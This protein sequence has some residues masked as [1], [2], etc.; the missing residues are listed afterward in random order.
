MRNARPGRIDCVWNVR[1][2]NQTGKFEII[3]EELKR[4]EIDVASISETHWQGQ[5]HFKSTS[6]TM[7]RS[8]TGDRNIHG[9]GILVANKLTDFVMG[10][11]AINERAMTLKINAKPCALNI[12][13]L[14]APT[15]D[16]EDEE[17]EEFYQTVEDAINKIPNKEILFIMGDFNAKIGSTLHDDHIRQVVGKFGLGDRNERGERLIDFCIDNSLTIVN[18]LFDHHKRRL[19]TWRSPDGRTKNQIDYILTRQRWKS[20][21]RAAKTLPS[22]DCG[23]DHQLLLCEFIGKLKVCKRRQIKRLPKISSDQVA[24]FNDDA[25]R[26]IETRLVQLQTEDPEAIWQ[27]LKESLA[28]TLNELPEDI[29]NSTRQP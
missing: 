27:A 15:L 17:V 23:R 14:Y 2:L 19:Y 16:A 20:S 25:M 3:Q 13:A 7:Y 26:K 4:C 1:G 6:Y 28:T 18:S 24:T 5:G 12:M 10:Y 9:V 22:A 21:V 8:G 11:E 29:E